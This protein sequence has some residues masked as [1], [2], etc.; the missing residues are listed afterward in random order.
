MREVPLQLHLGARVLVTERVGPE[1][2]CL[3][4]VQ[5][6]VLAGQALL[7]LLARTVEEVSAREVVPTEAIE[8]HYMAPAPG[9]RAQAADAGPSEWLVGLLRVVRLLVQ[10]A[11]ATMG[12]R[13]VGPV[14]LPVN[15]RCCCHRKEQRAPAADP[16]RV[17]TGGVAAVADMLPRPAHTQNRRSACHRSSLACSEHGHTFRR[18]SLTSLE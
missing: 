12:T 1:T 6:L 2:R 18:Q 11:E 7:R 10:S 17:A 13:I 3:Q 4:T 8:S 9:V 16:V 5:S 14:S 15:Q